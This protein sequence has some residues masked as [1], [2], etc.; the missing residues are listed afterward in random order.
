MIE[1]SP[2][3][4]FY[5][6]PEGSP[7]FITH[8]LIIVCSR[9]SC[10]HSDMP[11]FPLCPQMT[12][13]GISVE[14]DVAVSGSKVRGAVLRCQVCLV[15]QLNSTIQSAVFN[16][17]K[18]SWQIVAYLLDSLCLWTINPIACVSLS[19][20]F[21]TSMFSWGDKVKHTTHV[22]Y[23]NWCAVCNHHGNP[24]SPLQLFTPALPLY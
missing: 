11:T 6:L 23:V 8:F 17:S 19:M 21:S 20:L 13:V 10:W 4:L 2:L 14:L 22:N 24:L 12:C 15:H 7:E 18:G 5:V 1:P 3:A 9:E 16:C